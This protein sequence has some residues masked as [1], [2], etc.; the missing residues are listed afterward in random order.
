MKMGGV[1]RRWLMLWL[2]WASTGGCV[3]SRVT[4][5]RLLPLEPPV[6]ASQ[7]AGRIAYL[8]QLQAV[9]TAVQLQFTDYRE[10]ERGVGRAYPSAGG[11]LVLRRP[12]FIRLQVQASLL[13][14][15]AD[16]TSDGER[17]T[18]AV[19]YPAD[20]RAFI[21]GSNHKTYNNLSSAAAGRRDVSVFAGLRPQHL[22]VPLLP[23]P[24]PPSGPDASWSVFETRRDEL[25]TIGSRSVWVT[26]T[27]YLLYVAQRNQAGQWRPCFAYWFDRT[28]PGTPLMRMEVFDEGGALSTM[29]E[30]GGYAAADGSHKLLPDWVRIVRPAEGYALRVVFQS[31]EINPAS[32][33]ED[34][35]TLTNDQNLK[36][37][38]LDAQS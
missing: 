19:F 37:I 25:E 12:Q 3:T 34:V 11:A 27:Y 16:M 24:I 13:G 31:P 10:A 9:R 35:F 30:F 8:Q 29:S 7:L 18:V 23:P 14:S 6:T 38:D 21:R 26:R 28:R 1:W 17:F 4:L 33:P 2:V 15:L 22:S 5:P 32:L 20:R 36:V